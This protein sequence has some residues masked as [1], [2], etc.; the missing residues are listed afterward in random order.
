M[1]GCSPAT[2]ATRPSTD[3]VAAFV[4]G[5]P[6][7][8]ATLWE[9]GHGGDQP[10]DTTH[11]FAARQGRVIVLRHPA[12]DHSVFALLTIPPADRDDS[13]TVRVAPVPGRYSVAI[14]GDPLPSGTTLA[15]SY[16]IHFAPPDSARPRYPTGSRFERAL[17][18]G[19]LQSDGRV[20]LLASE[21]PAMDVLR[22]AISGRGT[23]LVAA[24]R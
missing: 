3:P 16:A 19:Q 15:F 8:R 7:P 6:V 1:A 22:T 2:I 4:A 23:Y 11:R 24:P 10:S 21:R 5:P 14:T 18:I 13:L 20:Q 9:L 12:P 17:A